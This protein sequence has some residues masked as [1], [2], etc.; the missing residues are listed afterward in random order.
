[1]SIRVVCCINEN[2]FANCSVV[3][4][5]GRK[6]H[7]MTAFTI[8]MQ[9]CRFN[10]RL[11]CMYVQPILYIK[12]SNET[13]PLKRWVAILQEST[14]LYAGFLLNIHNNF[15][16]GIWMELV[17]YNMRLKSFTRFI[18]NTKYRN[19]FFPYSYTRF[20]EF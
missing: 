1:M 10:T 9:R 2:Y 4:Q 12:I 14:I 6:C 5:N 15:L 19:V 13:P 11:L 17:Y 7:I 8:H 20:N 18:F 16:Y 3:S